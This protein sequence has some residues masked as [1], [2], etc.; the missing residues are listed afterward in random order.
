MKK[1]TSQNLTK[2]LQY[3]IE[4]GLDVF[5]KL[6]MR[7]ATTTKIARRAGVSIGTLYNYFSNK[8][9]LLKFIVHTFLSDT[10][11]EFFENLQGLKNKDSQDVVKHFV[12]F[13]FDRIKKNKNFMKTLF[14]YSIHFDRLKTMI[15][16]RKQFAKQLSEY[17][18]ENK[19]KFQSTQ[20]E[21]DIYIALTIFMGIVQTY[22]FDP[23]VD[24]DQ[25]LDLLYRQECITSI[26]SY[27]K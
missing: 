22:V 15:E 12:T 10:K 27:L 25:D 3:I 20:L 23:D 11:K 14:I 4:A 24:D 13:A 9:D 18:Q 17:I 5:G 8:E 2:N 16:T 7:S 1:K 6:G 26:C 21:K 19:I